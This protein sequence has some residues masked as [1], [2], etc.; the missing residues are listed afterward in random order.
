MG[1]DQNLRSLKCWHVISADSCMT[2]RSAWG[3]VRFSGTVIISICIEPDRG[4]TT[5]IWKFQTWLIDDVRGENLLFQVNQVLLTV[6]YLS[7]RWKVHYGRQIQN[8]QRNF[9][10]NFSLQ[11]HE[12]K[13][14]IEIVNSNGTDKWN[15][16]EFF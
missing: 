7:N 5:Q 10:K 12:R 9:S 4:E 13:V 11:K 1:S 16:K 8:R 6:G 3:K 15:M 14:V 2:V